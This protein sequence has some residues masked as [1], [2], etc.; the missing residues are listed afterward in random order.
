ME[1][2]FDQWH[3]RLQIGPKYKC[4]AIFVDN[5]G[6][7]I[8]MGIFPFARELLRNGTRVSVNTLIVLDL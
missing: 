2:D 5:S 4:A 7:D 1:D 8:I 6:I 3:Q